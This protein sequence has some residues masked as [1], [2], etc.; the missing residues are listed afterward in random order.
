MNDERGYW[1]WNEDKGDLIVSL[2]WLPLLAYSLKLLIMTDWQY[3]FYRN[4]SSNLSHQLSADKGN[5]LLAP[6]FNR[7][8]HIPT[9]EVG[10][11]LKVYGGITKE[12]FA[13]ARKF[14]FSNAAE[15]VPN[16]R[17]AEHAVRAEYVDGIKASK[18]RAGILKKACLRGGV[19]SLQGGN[20][21]ECRPPYIRPKSL[22]YYGTPGLNQES[23]TSIIDGQFL[24]VPC[25]LDSGGY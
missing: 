14:G 3:R 22:L 2:P 13:R 9:A 25:K 5:S 21:S 24:N 12:S 6:K 1:I 15:W 23:P 18:S 7:Q 20:E 10:Y 19:K 4:H 17:G 11:L 16:S 8:R